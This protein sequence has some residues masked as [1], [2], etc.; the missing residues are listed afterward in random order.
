VET[1]AAGCSNTHSVVV[2]VNQLPLTAGIISGA[3][4]V[5]PG[6]KVTYT[7]P[8]IANATSYVW[9]LPVG[10]TGSSS[11]N[12][13]TVDFGAAA[14]DGNI[15]V[16][17]S[18]AC[19]EGTASSLAIKV[20]KAPVANAGAAQTVDE[21]K[22][23]TLDGSLSSDPDGNNLTYNWVAPAGITLSS[24][25]A[26]KPVFSAPEVKADTDFAIL[27]TVNDGSLSSTSSTVIISVKNIIKTTADVIPQNILKT[28]PNPTN[29][30]VNIE[31]IPLSGKTN[32]SVYTIDGRLIFSKTSN[33]KTEKIDISN[34]VSGTYLIKVNNQIV[35]ILKE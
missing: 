18:N 3:A 17:G 24:K 31:G 29:G 7:V 35:K 22:L 1:N 25:T 26:A 30:I 32:I 11:A 16:K 2:P 8:V 33:N 9:T 27:L 4:V 34:H 15:S 28:Y 19:G 20:N 14:V 23:V 13:I 21:G 10:A 12:S 5:N 6:Q